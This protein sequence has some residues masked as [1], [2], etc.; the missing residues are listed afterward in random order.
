[1]ILSLAVTQQAIM[2]ACFEVELPSVKFVRIEYVPFL[3]RFSMV[4]FMRL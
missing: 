2:K 3:D 4:L 1:M